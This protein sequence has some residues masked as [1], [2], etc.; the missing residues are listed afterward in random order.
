MAASAAFR[1]VDAVMERAMGIEP[2]RPA[3]EAGVLP[4]NYARASRIKPDQTCRRYYYSEVKPFRQGVVLFLLTNPQVF[5]CRRASDPAFLS[6][7]APAPPIPSS[8][9]SSLLYIL[10]IYTGKSLSGHD[11]P[12]HRPGFGNVLTLP[13]RNLFPPIQSC[14]SQV[15]SLGGILHTT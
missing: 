4:L 12:W 11:G 10:I 7:A 3:W 9:S 1:L 13:E 8:G 5:F 14:Q 15:A 2:T 6:Y